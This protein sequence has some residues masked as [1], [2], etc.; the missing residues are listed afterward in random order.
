MVAAKAN[1]AC[2]YRF[3]EPEAAGPKSFFTEI[4]A[5]VSD[6]KFAK[7]GRYLLSRDYMTLKV[8]TF[9]VSIGIRYDVPLIISG[10]FQIMRVR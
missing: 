8:H 10:W 1:I 6:I 2:F 3:E 4:I 5:S 9:I 7:E